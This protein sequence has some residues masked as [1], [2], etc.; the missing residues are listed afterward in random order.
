ME[1]LINILLT[2]IIIGMLYFLYTS[3]IKQISMYQSSIKEQ[4]ELNGFCLQLKKDFFKAGKIIN[5]GNTFKIFFYDTKSVDYAITENYIYR[6]Q[7]GRT[8]SLRIKKVSKNWILTPKTKEQL[9]NAL[10][11]ET[12]LFNKPVNYTLTKDYQSIKATDNTNGN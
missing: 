3:F 8:D 4:N 10:V 6:K 5:S 9:V 7:N 1:V 12:M 11:I 2:A